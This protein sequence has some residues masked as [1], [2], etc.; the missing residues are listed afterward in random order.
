MRRKNWEEIQ[1][2][3]GGRIETAADFSVI[4]DP[5]LRKRLKNDDDK[6]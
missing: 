2:N 6:L 5:Y 1:E 4:V 3:R